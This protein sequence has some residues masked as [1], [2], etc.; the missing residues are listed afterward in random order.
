MLT[1]HQ[2]QIIQQDKFTI[3]Q[4]E[5]FEEQTKT[6]KKQTK[7]I[8]DKSRNSSPI[9]FIGFKALSHFCRNILNSSIEL[10]K[11]QEDK[12]NFKSNLNK[13]AK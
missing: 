5:I 13:K 8:E 11:S 2:K 9:N 3:L 4:W 6:I 1:F 10:A 12:E 7:T